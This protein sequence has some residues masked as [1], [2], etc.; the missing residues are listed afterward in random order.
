MPFFIASTWFVHCDT[1]ATPDLCK[2][3]ALAIAGPLAILGFANSLINPVIYAW[4]HNGFRQSVKELYQRYCCCCKKKNESITATDSNPL[5]DS[6]T[7]NTNVQSSN[8][9]SSIEIN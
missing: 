3:L 2:N 7:Q 6:S 5:A 9:V 1:E 8:G 4:W